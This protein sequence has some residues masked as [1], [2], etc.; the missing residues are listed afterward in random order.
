MDEGRNL[1]AITL[2][3]KHLVPRSPFGK[4]KTNLFKLASMIMNKNQNG[5]SHDK[6]KPPQNE[7]TVQMEIESNSIE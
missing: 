6:S 3:Q 5:Y 1:E 4:D 2:L 7:K